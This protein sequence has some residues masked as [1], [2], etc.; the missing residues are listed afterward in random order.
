[1]TTLQPHLNVITQHALSSD[2]LDMISSGSTSSEK[3]SYVP[4][5]KNYSPI[6]VSAA[7]SVLLNQYKDYMNMYNEKLGLEAEYAKNQDSKLAQEIQQL[8]IALDKL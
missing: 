2:L 4:E 5:K 6:E 3:L 7:V 1:M 8:D